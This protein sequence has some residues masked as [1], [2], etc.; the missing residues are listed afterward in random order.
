MPEKRN[1]KS[2]PLLC[3]CYCYLDSITALNATCKTMCIVQLLIDVTVQTI[4]RIYKNYNC[5]YYR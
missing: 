5:K 1:D 4:T 2:I 3:Q